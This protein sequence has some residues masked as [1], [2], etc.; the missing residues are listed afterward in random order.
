MN[1]SWLKILIPQAAMVFLVLAVFFIC[2]YFG[3]EDKEAVIVT[4]VTTTAAAVAVATFATTA[5]V[6]ATFATTAAAVAFAVTTAKEYK[7]PIFW[8][9][10]SYLV[11]TMAI[12]LPIYLS[13]N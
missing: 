8:V 2:R 13:I 10:A 4:T 12:F 6:V 9:V 3:L 5:A 1:R 11:E 7:L